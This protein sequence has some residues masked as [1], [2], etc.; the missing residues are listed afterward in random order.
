[1]TLLLRIFTDVLHA[2]LRGRRFT[3]HIEPLKPVPEKSLQ[4][5]KSRGYEPS[6]TGVAY[7]TFEGV[8][9]EYVYPAYFWSE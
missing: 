2:Q 6:G 4:L 5:W 1:M 9:K 7:V 8:R 3:Y